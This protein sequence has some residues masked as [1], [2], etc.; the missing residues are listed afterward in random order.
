[1]GRSLSNWTRADDG[2]MDRAC[3]L[4]RVTSLDQCSCAA[5][6]KMHCLLDMRIAD[7]GAGFVQPSIVKFALRS[8][9]NYR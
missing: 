4:T 9:Y 2:R 5:L 8:R 6:R 1:M 7:D 3:G